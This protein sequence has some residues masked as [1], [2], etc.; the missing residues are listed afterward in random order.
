MTIIVYSVDAQQDSSL[1]PTVWGELTREVLLASGVSGN[2][3]CYLSFV[4]PQ[5]IA[6]LNMEYMG[7]Q[8]PTDVLSFPVSFEVE[9]S[10][11]IPRIL[12]EIYICCDVARENSQE[13]QDDLHDGSLEDELALL[14]V[15]GVLHLS[16]MDHEIEEEAEVMEARERD[17]LNDFYY[18]KKLKH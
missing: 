18:S 2:A 16:G 10:A 6:K 8:G 4:S 14:V 17:L 5:E 9:I 7:K 1:D 13:H 11:E 15:H 3:E 12:G